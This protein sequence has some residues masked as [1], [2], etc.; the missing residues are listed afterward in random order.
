[1]SKYTKSLKACLKLFGAAALLFLFC[2]YALF[3]AGYC[4]KDNSWLSYGEKSELAR[5]YLIDFHDVSEFIKSDSTYFYEELDECCN[6]RFFPYR[7]DSPILRNML[8]AAINLY[9]IYSSYVEIE[10][11][12]I[13]KDDEKSIKTSYK[14]YV[15][16]DNCG[17][18]LLFEIEP[19]QTHTYKS[20]KKQ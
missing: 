15:S 18:T 11:T 16:V 3:F 14:A 19:K 13:K 12:E 17:K 7:E 2:R 1:M 5:H 8:S 20:K 9:F 10:F 6:V 4:Y